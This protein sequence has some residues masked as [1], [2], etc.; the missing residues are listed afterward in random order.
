VVWS[1]VTHKRYLVACANAGSEY[2]DRGPHTISWGVSP[3]STQSWVDFRTDG[4]W[5]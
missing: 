1:P 3:R 5:S 4:S 2:G